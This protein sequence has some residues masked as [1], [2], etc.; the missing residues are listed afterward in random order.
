MARSKFFVIRD[1]STVSKN[2][3]VS[4]TKEHSSIKMATKEATRLAKEN[5]ISRFFV[6]SVVQVVESTVTLK[7]K[8]SEL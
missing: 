4:P 7:I 1:P 5:P 3:N 2:Y 8:R 6:V